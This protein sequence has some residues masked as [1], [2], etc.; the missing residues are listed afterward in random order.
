[1]V[2]IIDAVERKNSKDEVFTSFILSGG[3][4]MVKSQK[5]KFY[6]TTRK[7]SVP[8][9]L[10]LK[11]AKQMIGQ[12]MT[13]SIIK[14]VCAPYLFKTQSGEEIEIEFTYEYSEEGTTIEES[15]FQGQ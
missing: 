12:K 6:A 4:E 1:M 5:G 2:T 3:V 9:T 15:V 11:V 13:G 8:C 10:S 7:A 14:K